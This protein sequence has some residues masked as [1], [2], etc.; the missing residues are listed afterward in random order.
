[1]PVVGRFLVG[2]KASFSSTFCCGTHC[3]LIRG[4]VKA[5]SGQNQLRAKS[6]RRL[7][8]NVRYEARRI[9]ANSAEL[10]DLLVRVQRK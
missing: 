7:T 5:R 3:A 6:L 1:V 2:T 9:T 10:P 8:E 4:R